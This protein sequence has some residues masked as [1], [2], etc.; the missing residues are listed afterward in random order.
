MNLTRRQTGLAF[1]ASLTALLAAC[2]TNS[3]GLDA[4]ILSDVQGLVPATEAIEAAL[5]SYAPNAITPA[6]QA[7]I[8]AL[9]TAAIAALNSLTS[10]TPVAT[11]ASML[12]TIDAYLNAALS[13]VGAALPAAS[14]AF[15]ALAPFVPMY[16]AA[17]ALVEGVLEPYINSVI[18]TASTMKPAA[19]MTLHT[20]K[21]HFT[22]AAA[23]E[24]LH[25][26]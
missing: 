11:A 15:P 20:V 22:P 7:K 23:R 16:D 4:T 25:I 12:T 10:A 2:G 18:T 6:V 5:M 13:A 24:V 14:A 26:H 21:T 1:A 19:K 3:A 17:V 9:E 8:A